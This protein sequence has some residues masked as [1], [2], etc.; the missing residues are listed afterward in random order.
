MAPFVVFHLHF[1][2]GNIEVVETVFC[3]C[4]WGCEVEVAAADENFHGRIADEGS[5]EAAH[6]IWIAPLVVI[7]KFP[8]LVYI[9]GEEGVGILEFKLFMEIF[10]KGCRKNSANIGAAWVLINCVVISC[11][12]GVEPA[13]H[14]ALVGEE[15][16]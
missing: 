1:G 9:D 13:D 15:V 2:V 12:A 11:D 3:S 6:E 14:F 5:T 10:M 16:V 7:I 4:K 8:L